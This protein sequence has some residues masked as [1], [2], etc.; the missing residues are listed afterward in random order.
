VS[1]GKAVTTARFPAP[2]AYKL[3]ATATDPG[4]LATRTEVVVTVPE[5]RSSAGQP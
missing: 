4:P 2:G 5:T 3:V 1:D